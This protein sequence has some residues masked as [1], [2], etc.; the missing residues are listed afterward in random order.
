MDK[1]RQS[2]HSENLSAIELKRLSEKA[3]IASVYH[4]AVEKDTIQIIALTIVIFH[5]THHHV[6]KNRRVTD[7]SVP[8]LPEERNPIFYIYPACMLMN[9]IFTY[10]W[11][12]TDKLMRGPYIPLIGCFVAAFLLFLA[13]VIEMKHADMYLDLSEISDAE[14]ISHPVFIHN[15]IMA[16]LSLFCMNIYLI[17]AWILVDYWQ[18]IREYNISDASNDVPATDSSTET[19]LSEI[20]KHDHKMK[21]M[22]GALDPIPKLEKF[23]SLSSISRTVSVNVEDEP[24]IFYCCFVDFHNY[25]K[26]RKLLGRPLHEFK[27][28]H[29]M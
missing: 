24:V 27:V 5:Y 25:M 6:N 7:D 21:E 19:D 8:Y 20:S 29:V 18:S 2:T 9:S 1:R 12:Y 11:L 28:V 4:R 10:F 17:Q 23:P 13:A 15:F 26:H 16:L 14:L 3:K 22:P